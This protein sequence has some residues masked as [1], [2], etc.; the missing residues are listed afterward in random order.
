MVFL[1]EHADMDPRLDILVN[2]NLAASMSV[3]K[4]FF[5]VVPHRRYFARLCERA[6]VVSTGMYTEDCMFSK[7]DDR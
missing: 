4:T 3:M 6:G 5:I 1:G 2:S 7:S